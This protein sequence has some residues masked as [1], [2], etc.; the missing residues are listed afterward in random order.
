[1]K[2]QTETLSLSLD[3][4]SSSSSNNQIF[5]GLC[6]NETIGDSRIWMPTSRPQQDQSQQ[7]LQKL[8]PFALPLE[9]DW[10][11]D[12]YCCLSS[13]SSDDDDDDDDEDNEYDVDID[14]TSFYDEVASTIIPS[15]KKGVSFGKV[16][17]REYSVVLGDHTA[18]TEGYPLSLSW[19]YNPEHTVMDLDEH[20]RSRESLKR[21]KLSQRRNLLRLVGG[22][23]LW[24][25][26]CAEQ[27]R[28]NQLLKEEE[29]Q[30]QQQPCL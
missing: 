25:L 12:D 5:Y 27:E 22:Y 10:S 30:Q 9:N 17:V 8:S 4:N 16:Q 29:Q 28:R 13:E 11:Q 21:L 15:R 7:A 18:P 3:N 26:Q 20:Q 1:M 23:T 2:I 19:E 6:L 24:Q 14:L